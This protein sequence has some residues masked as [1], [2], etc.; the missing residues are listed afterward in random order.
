[1]TGGRPSSEK[2]SWGKPMTAEQGRTE[3]ALTT[4]EIAA[5]STANDSMDGAS[6]LLPEEE[7]S[8]YLD[9]W[10]TIQSK[11][12]DEPEVSVREADGLVAGVIQKLAAKFAEER[13]NLEKQW[14]GGGEV[15]TEDLRQA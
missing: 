4:S 11:F 9:Q 1:M 6:S 3:T 2:I 5:R 7:R 12:V 10:S 8:T 13:A 14:D 15:N